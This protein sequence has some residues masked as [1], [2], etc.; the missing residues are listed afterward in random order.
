[1]DI[2]ND[3]R[4]NES[5]VSRRTA[6]VPKRID[7]P[8]AKPRKVRSVAEVRWMPVKRWWRYLWNDEQMRNK[9]RVE[10]QP[11]KFQVRVVDNHLIQYLL[12]MS[13]RMVQSQLIMNIWTY[14]LSIYH[15]ELVVSELRHILCRFWGCLFLTYLS[16]PVTNRIYCIF[17]RKSQPKPSVSTVLLGGMAEHP[18]S[19][20]PPTD[21]R[22]VPSLCIGDVMALHQVLGE[23]RWKTWRQWRDLGKSWRIGGWY[24]WWFRNPAITTWHV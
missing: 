7:H 3:H 19:C 24:C 15:S 9:V 8:S 5:P 13:L 22:C 2:P 17:C 14:F 23:N 6:E 12:K 18:K 10:Y 1:M 21:R 16:L 4:P 20:K 11:G